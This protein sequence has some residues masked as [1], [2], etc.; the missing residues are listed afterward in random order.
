MPKSPTKSQLLGKRAHG[1]E[2]G[3]QNPSKS[4]KSK[5]KD[6]ESDIPVK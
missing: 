4:K 3:S 6:S 2:S 1:D 5:T